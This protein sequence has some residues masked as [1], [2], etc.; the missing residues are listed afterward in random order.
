MNQ[1]KLESL[2]EVCVNIAIGFVVSLLFWTFVVVPVLNIPVTMSQNL[3]VTI[4]FTVLAIVRGYFVRR[5]FN[6]G[7]HRLVHKLAARLVS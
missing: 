6:A 1:T 3:G 2:L 5:F 7:I 4:S